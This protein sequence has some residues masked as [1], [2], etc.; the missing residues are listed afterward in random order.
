MRIAIVGCGW[1]GSILASLLTEYGR[2]DVYERRPRPSTEGAWGIPTRE[3]LRLS[4]RLGLNG[5][6]YILWRGR[7]LYA[8]FVTETSLKLGNL[9]TFDKQAF[10]NDLVESSDARFHFSKQF[11]DYGY[12]V[13]IDATGRRAVLGKTGHEII[14]A[15]YQVEA[16]FRDPPYGDFYIDFSEPRAG[17][18]LWMFPLGGNRFH[19]GCGAY[20]A[21]YSRRKVREFLERHG[22]E[23]LRVR[24]KPMRL[25]RPCLSRPFLMGRVI[26]VGESIGAVSRLGEG[27]LPSAETAFLLAENLQSPQNYEREVSKMLRK[28]EHGY[29]LYDALEKQSLKAY[30]AMARTFGELQGRMSLKPNLLTAIN[31]TLWPITN[32]NFL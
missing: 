9:C 25:C 7:R 1:T 26:G 27:N 6:E 29:D 17:G 12:D 8:R 23:I 20:D 21:S 3:F 10:I 5:E 24:T 30:V 14:R 16:F 22:G 13:I 18:Y 11:R 31:L 19:V 4:R 28:L 15:P 32:I 2:V